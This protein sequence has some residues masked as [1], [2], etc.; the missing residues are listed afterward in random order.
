M[1]MM[2]QHGECFAVGVKPPSG[3]I[4][5]LCTYNIYIYIHTC[6][7]IQISNNLKQ[8]KTDSIQTSFFDPEH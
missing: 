8:G 2:N 4:M 7:I 6:I 1:Y 5:L 3:Y